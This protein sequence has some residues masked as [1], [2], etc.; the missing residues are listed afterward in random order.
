MD[1]GTVMAFTLYASSG[2][3]FLNQ[4]ELNRRLTGAAFYGASSEVLWE[5][6]G[7]RKRRVSTSKRSSCQVMFPGHVAYIFAEDHFVLSGDTICPKSIKCQV[8]P[9]IELA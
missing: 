6:L 5:D 8:A 3:S 7:I 4:P 1:G 9:Y 2:V